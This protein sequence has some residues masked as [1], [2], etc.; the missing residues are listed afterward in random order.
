MPARP[1]PEIAIR[2]AVPADFPRIVELNAAEA[3]HTS[4]MDADQLARLDELACYHRVAVANE[5]IVAFLL[6]IRDGAAYENDNYRWFAEHFQRF[7]YVDRIVVNARSA[8]LGIG[9]K[10]YRDL[11]ADA[12]AQGID[13][14]AC[15][16]NIEPPNPVS[17]AFHARFGFAEK[18]TQWVAGG[19]K[20]V[21]LQAADTG[22]Q[23]RAILR[24]AQRA[25]VPGIQR[26]RHAVR[27]NRLIS[28]VIADEDVVREMEVTGRGWVIEVHS[29]VVAFAIGN[30]ET[31]NIWA[32]FVD[33]AHE[34]QGYGRRLHD[35][36]LGW[37]WAQGLTRLWLSTDPGTRAEGFY[38]RAGWQRREILPSGE[39]LFDWL[40]IDA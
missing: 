10:L 26:V 32:L 3:D 20:R 7:V 8:R 19:S 12:R 2:D 17:Q 28:I 27:E 16:F 6:A 23:A 11:F 21:S 18:G 15:E 34:G 22:L 4:A 39:V 33:P 38:L 14:L 40:V 30:S 29:E 25:D 37:L 36:M 13:T 5:A 9:S 24:Q 35:E 1:Q 31:G